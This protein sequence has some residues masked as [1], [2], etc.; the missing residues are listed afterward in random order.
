MLQRN[1][2]PFDVAKISETL[3]H[4]LEIRPLFLLT[5]C[6][7]EDSDAGYLLGLLRVGDPRQ[8]DCDAAEKRDEISPSH[9]FGD[10]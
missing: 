9:E 1:R 10:W 6:V 7:P 2:A 8:Y 3:L 4:R 5:R